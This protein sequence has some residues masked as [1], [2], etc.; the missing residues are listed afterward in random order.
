MRF[1]VENFGPVKFADVTLSDF[2]VFIGPGGT[3]KSYLAYLI[4]MLQRIETDFEVLSDSI[5][6]SAEFKEAFKEIDEKKSLSE[7]TSARLIRML[8]KSLEKSLK[9][10]LPDHFKSTFRVERVGKLVS[11]DEK[12]KARIRVCNNDN[13]QGFEILIYKRSNRVEL[14]GL[15][16]LDVS[17]LKMEYASDKIYL[18]YN[19][20]EILERRLAL[21]P[22]QKMPQEVRFFQI[23]ILT[24]PYIIS[25]LLDGYFIY[26]DSYILTDSKSGF[27]RMAPNLIRYSLTRTGPEDVPLSKPDREMLSNLI[28]E[29]SSKIVDD[30]ISSIADFLENEIGGKV[31]VKTLGMVFPEIYFRRSRE[32]IPILRSHSGAR[33][34]APLIIYLRHVLKPKSFI[35]IEEPETHLHPNM[36]N[37][38]ARAL[39]MLSHKISVLITTHSPTI[40]EELNSLIH[41]N[42][43]SKEEKV[44]IGY[45]EHEGLKP[46]NL[47]I[48]RFKNDGTAEEVIV[49]DEGIEE[50]EFSS[51]IVELSN[52]YAEIEEALWR[53]MNA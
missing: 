18:K 7:E 1:I 4:W 17:G 10:S 42:K 37:V 26:K 8:L 53:K 5:T 40:L 31:E 14:K 38:V 25:T 27:L 6:N 50:E 33:E 36:Q 32:E 35:V 39:A 47:R 51:V 9:K 34:L 11:W 16:K 44:K 23:C 12:S 43:L 22:G 13:T 20:R 45:K 46:E 29:D 24:I 30:G 21:P 19:G 3:G 49:S 48:Y 2:T 28:V 15:D 41:L 52:R